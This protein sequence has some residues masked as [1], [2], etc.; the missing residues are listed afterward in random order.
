MANSAREAL[1]K[2]AEIMGFVAGLCNQVR[3]EVPDSVAPNP[4]FGGA[5][6][7]RTQ[8]LFQA[9]FQGALGWSGKSRQPVSWQE[10]QNGLRHNRRTTS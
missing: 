7:D 2:A 6:P 10:W 9:G 3:H 1:E 5:A 8:R 4:Q